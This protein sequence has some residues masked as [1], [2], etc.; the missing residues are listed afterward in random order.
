FLSLAGTGKSHLV[1]AIAA[2]AIVSVWVS[3]TKNDASGIGGLTG[4]ESTFNVSLQ[5]GTFAGA[6]LGGGEMDETNLSTKVIPTTGM[7]ED[8]MANIWVLQFDAS[9]GC[10][11]SQ[12]YSS[13]NPENF[14]VTLSNGTAQ[15]VAFVAN[16]FDPDL[17][18]G[19][20]GTWGA[21]QTLTKTVSEATIHTGAGSSD[22]Y[23]LIS[24]IY[25]GDIT[26]AGLPAAVQMKRAVAKVRIAWSI[27]LETAGERFV[28]ASLQLCNAAA[29]QSYM[30]PA[31]SGGAG[32]YPAASAANFSTYE[33]MS[34]PM[35][36]TS[37]WYVAENLRGTGSGTTAFDKNAE[38]AQTGQGAY[39]TYID[40]QGTYTFASGETADLS[41]RFY[42]GGDVTADYNVRR[43]HIYDLTVR[44]VGANAADA[45]ISVTSAGGTWGVDVEGTGSTTGDVKFD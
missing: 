24:G 39:C 27:D 16:T 5:A 4:G 23:L 18:A 28:P 25:K 31:A 32:L 37:T 20:S 41:Y 3:C 36:G 8:Q 11:R 2:W 13:Y 9:G 19:Y 33:A 45:R 1:A 14:P 7:H 17:F 34:N 22:R 6:A 44:I 35:A 26:A 12:Y 10:V 30:E 40:L 21:F 42:L 43:N 29:T 38:T 15:T